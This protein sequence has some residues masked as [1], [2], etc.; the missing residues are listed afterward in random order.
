MRYLIVLEQTDFGF[1][2]Q[3]PDLA[4]VT[5]GKSI[6][7]AKRAAIEAIKINIDAYKEA[8]KE[9]PK[10]ESVLR[11]LENSDFADLLFTY[12]NVYNTEENIAA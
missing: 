9:I 2:V 4:L 5:Y 8:G 1:S 7:E 11:H 10:K 3:V 6:D 12:I